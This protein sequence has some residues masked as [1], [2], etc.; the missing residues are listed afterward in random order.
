MKRVA[1][2]A[3]CLIAL[4]V[5]RCLVLPRVLPA[6]TIEYRGQRIK[7]SKRY[8]DYDEY[9]NDPANIHVSEVARVQNLVRSAPVPRACG[10]FE[11]VAA[12]VHQ[13]V[14]PGYGSGSLASE[15]EVLR[16]FSVEVPQADEAR[17]FV[18]TRKGAEWC[19]T[20]D[21]AVRGGSPARVAG[22]EGK[23]VFSD[24]SNRELAVREWNRP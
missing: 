20:D 4:V 15:W 10:S 19:V 16:A 5:L 14:F 7:L 17:V 23:L 3:A 9:K 1:L 6:G 8:F 11:A 21:F 12:P 13:V 24:P 22:R 18:L 2:V